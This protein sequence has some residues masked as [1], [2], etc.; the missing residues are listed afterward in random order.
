MARSTWNGWA[1]TT[2]WNASV[3]SFTE[4]DL[5]LLAAIGRVLSSRYQSIPFAGSAAAGPYLFE[6]LVEDRHVSA[7]LDPSPYMG[8]GELPAKRDVVAET[9]EVLRQSSL[10]TYESHRISTGVILISQGRDARDAKPELPLGAVPY[11]SALVSIKSFHRLCDGL[12]TVFLVN[13]EGMLVDL[14]DV[15]RYV[16]EYGDVLLPTPR[17]ERYRAHCLAT[18]SG[19]NICLVLTPNGEIKIFA[20]GVRSSISWKDDGT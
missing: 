18:A 8:E 19:G 7:F 15:E 2:T 1:H 10:I 9:I 4:H 3:R 11:T 16:R 6:G 5:R 14:V 13:P 17:P 20:G 12:H